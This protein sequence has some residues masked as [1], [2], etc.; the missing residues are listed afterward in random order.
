MFRVKNTSKL[1]DKKSYSTWTVRL[2]RYV[3][4]GDES[5]ICITIR[6]ELGFVKRSKFNKVKLKAV[7]QHKEN[8]CTPS[9][10]RS[11]AE[12]LI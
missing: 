11:E 9:H 3:N 8:N 12:L 1:H 2:N 5:K 10:D 6:Y 7:Y 4:G